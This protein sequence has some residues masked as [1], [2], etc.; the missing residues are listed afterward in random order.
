MTAAELL[1]HLLGR[2]SVDVWLKPNGRIGISGPETLLAEIRPALRRIGAAA[3]RDELRE[4]DEQSRK[5]LGDL[6]GDTHRAA[7]PR[8]EPDR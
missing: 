7:Q 6:L 8:P 4:R 2:Y 5:R 3:I 1:D